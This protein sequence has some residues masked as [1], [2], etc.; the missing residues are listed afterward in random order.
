M[1]EPR[2]PGANPYL[3]PA[4][5]VVGFGLIAVALYAS[6]STAP[7]SPGTTPQAPVPEA[8]ASTPAPAPPAS[9]L[10]PEQTFTVGA[11]IGLWKP[12]VEEGARRCKLNERVQL[13]AGTKQLEI[14][15]ALK[16]GADG[17]IEEAVVDGASRTYALDGTLGPGP[18]GD[19]LSRCYAAAVKD[20]VR[21]P[22]ATSGGR[23][24]V[25]VRAV[26]R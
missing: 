12:H 23:L 19:E 2:A 1:S 25:H 26:D 9:L 13:D 10:P 14:P 16:V 15:V 11:F 8:T 5:I 4:S 22:P 7:V 17:R 20:W 3:I 21:F 24:D 6:R 18:G